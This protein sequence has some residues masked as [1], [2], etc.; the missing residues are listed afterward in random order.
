MENE[1]KVSE[2]PKNLTNHKQDLLSKEES[3]DNIVD[4]S[5]DIEDFYDEQGSDDQK[6]F[7]KDQTHKDKEILGDNEDLDMGYSQTHLEEFL[8]SNNGGKHTA[9]G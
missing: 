1:N 2:T 8:K 5:K 4:E 9:S 6:R 7:L 3:P